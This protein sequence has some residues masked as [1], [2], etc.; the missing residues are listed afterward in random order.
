[1]T[2]SA[3]THTTDRISLRALAP[4][5]YRAMLALD[6]AVK[7][8]P[9]LYELVKLRA[10]QL[11]GCAYCVDMHSRAAR[12]MGE[13]ERRIYA[14]GAWRESNFFTARERAAFAVCEAI[15]RLP[16][17]GLPDD[18]YEA[19]TEHFDDEE[20]AQLIFGCVTINAWNRI[21]VSTRM[22]PED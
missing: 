18:V 1:M 14:V 4:D 20:L 16:E 12:E 22:V 15:T 5:A 10:S 6:G 17:A 11:N 21:G 8:D 9:P 2:T 3:E 13:T 19:A 7:F